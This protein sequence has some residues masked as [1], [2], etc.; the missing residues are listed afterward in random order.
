[1][2]RQDGE[3]SGAEIVNSRFY[4]CVFYRLLSLAMF[5]G[6]FCEQSVYVVRIVFNKKRFTPSH[7]WLWQYLPNVQPSFLDRHLSHEQDARQRP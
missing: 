7:H 3:S 2:E 5:I 1:M 6:I 4:V